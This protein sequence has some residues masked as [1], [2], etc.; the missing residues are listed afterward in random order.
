M[1]VVDTS[2]L[3]DLFRGRATPA[4]NK[5]REL[6]RQSV[7]YMIPSICCQE[8]LQG[9]A[10]E[11]EWKLLAGHLGSQRLLDSTD[12]W[13]THMSAARI[14]YDCRRKGITVRSTIDCW[15][16]QLV[17]E[18]DGDLLHDDGDLEQMKK[19]RPLRTVRL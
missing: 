13:A 7:P 1:I 11:K 8:I 17:L 3:V 4:A 9:A 15:I 2:V 19:V 5:L 14:H 16:T 18:I 12:S 6:E 10:D